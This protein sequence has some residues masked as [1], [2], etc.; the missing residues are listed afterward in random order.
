ML[1]EVLAIVCGGFLGFAA[2][3][4]FVSTSIKEEKKK[5]EEIRRAKISS[6]STAVEK[7]VSESKMTKPPSDLSEFVD[8]LSDKYILGEIT[9]LTPE[10]LPI[11]SNSSTYEEDAAVAP[12]IMRVARRLLNSDRIVLSGEDSRILVMQANPDIILHAKI[13]RDISKREMDRIRDEV[14]MVMEGLL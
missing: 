4:K 6:I 1:Y 13:A 14:N 11:V 8:Y 12:E 5:E 2:T 7:R 10:G 3:W 9:I